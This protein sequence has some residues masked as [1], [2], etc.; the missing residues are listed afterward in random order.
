MFRHYLLR[1]KNLEAIW[2]NRNKEQQQQRQI[3]SQVHKS[4]G[5]SKS[6]HDTWRWDRYIL[7]RRL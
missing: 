4:T 6:L 7:P 3:L 5:Q 1:E 2:I